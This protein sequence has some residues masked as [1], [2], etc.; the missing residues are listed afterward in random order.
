MA[1]KKPVNAWSPPAD[2][3]KPTIGKTSVVLA[4][5]AFGAPLVRLADADRDLRGGFPFFVRL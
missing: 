4:G 5:T 3:P 1:S 2:A